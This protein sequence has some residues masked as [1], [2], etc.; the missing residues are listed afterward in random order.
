MKDLLTRLAGALVVIGAALGLGWWL[1]NRADGPSAGTTRDAG[2]PTQSR[3][4]VANGSN[5]PR[6]AG[7]RSMS[8]VSAAAELQRIGEQSQRLM[9]EGY[10]DIYVG[11]PLADLRRVRRTIQ[12][13]RAT[14]AGG[15]L[16][17]E[18]DPNGARVVYVVSEGNLVTQV[19]F[20]SRLDD[21]NGLGPHFAALQQTY[22]RPTGIWDCP[23]TQEA[24]PLRRFTWRREGASLMEAV[25]IHGNTVSITLVVSPTEDIGAALQYSRCAPVQNADQLAR[26]PVAGELRGERSTFVRELQRDAGR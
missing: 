9:P 3:E 26:F 24:P 13:S 7:R 21:P 5:E 12:R 15:S 20:M 25:L 10:R 2:A 14:A 4:P 23:E 8:G 18:D 22:G 1:L 16:W 6:D 11:M 19:Q 17:E